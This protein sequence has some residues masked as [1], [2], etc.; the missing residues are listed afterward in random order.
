MN[1]TI[2]NTN[3]TTKEQSLPSITNTPNTNNQYTTISPSNKMEHVY[4]RYPN[5]HSNNYNQSTDRNTRNHPESL[6]FK[7]S[8]SRTNQP[9][10]GQSR[11]TNQQ[12]TSTRNN[13]PFNP[14]NNGRG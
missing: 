5:N 14:N 2:E 1:D 10:Q 4:W 6:S 3:Q 9:Y 11:K 13:P 12:I 7:P 8:S